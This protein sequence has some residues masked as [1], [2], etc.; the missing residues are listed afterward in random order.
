[1]SRTTYDI[2]VIGGGAAGVFAGIHASARGKKVLLLEKT[3]KLLSKVKVSGGGRCNVTHNCEYAAQLIQNYPRG[4]RSL[5]KSFEAFGTGDTVRWFESHGVRLKVEEDGRMFPVSDS[6]QTIIDCLLEEASKRKL[7]IRLKTDVIKLLHEEDTFKV[8]LKNGDI[9]N[10]HKVIVTTGGQNKPESY[11]WLIDLGLKIERP[12]P[13]LFT[14]NVPDSDLKELKGLSV[15]K[16]WVQVPGT[17]WKQEG[18]VLITHWGFSAP[19][20]IKLSAWAAIDFFKWNY[21]FPILINWTGKDEETVR[22][23]FKIFREMHPKK[24]VSSNALFD[25]PARLWGALCSKAEINEEQRYMNLPKK[26]FNRLV[27][28]LV[29]CPY[30]VNGKTT[31]KEEFVT[32]GG[33]SLREVDLKTFE[34]R[35]IQGLY[36][37]GEVLD[38]DGVTGGF[39]FQHAWTS[40]Y[41]AGKNASE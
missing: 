37:A 33:I 14:F 35:K 11:Q 30:Q 39:N 31:F 28:M 18:P 16:G 27:E 24:V 34:S 36:F 15:N 3:T 10:S 17:K 29:R 20:V 13:S 12:I 32:C 22:E 23:E 41:I 19:A 25:I 1:M 2:I 26:Q 9:I 7:E 8:Q 5:R 38:V 21:Q 40:G 4:G 6:S